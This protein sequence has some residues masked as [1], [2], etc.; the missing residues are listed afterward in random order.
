MPDGSVKHVALL[1]KD[2]FGAIG[3]RMVLGLFSREPGVPG[4]SFYLNIDLD[5]KPTSKSSDSR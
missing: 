4:L 5:E 3:G 2:L 1:G